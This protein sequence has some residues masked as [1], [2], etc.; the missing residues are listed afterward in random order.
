MAD[1][2]LFSQQNTDACFDLLL[3]NGSMLNNLVIVRRVPNKRLVCRGDWNGQH[4]YAKIF[5]GSQAQRYAAR[6]AAGVG[7]L[8][9]ANIET[10]ALLYSGG[11]ADN[12]KVASSGVL[13]FSTVVGGINAEE[14]WGQSAR[15]EKVALAKKLVTELARHHNAGLMQTDLYLKNFLVKGDKIFTLDGDAIKPLPRLFTNQAALGNLAVLLSKF[16]VL[17][18]QQWLDSL[19]MAYAEARGWQKS[20]DT[21]R[22]QAL[23]MRHRHR[24][25]Q[26]Y[27][28]KKVFRQCTDVAIS[29]SWRHFLAMSRDEFSARLEHLLRDMPDTLIDGPSQQ[30]LKNGNTC[31]VGLTEINARKIVVKRYNIK[32]FWH[33]LG[34]FWR[35]SRAAASWSNAHR[36]I[37]HGIATA[38]PI[39]LMEQRFGPLRGEAYFLTEYIESVNLAD[40][41]QDTLLSQAQKQSVCQAIAEL[42]YKLSLLQIVHGDMKAS[43]IHI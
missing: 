14:A 28:N 34:R 11:L 12:S 8:L 29:R 5:I 3:D 36:L 27:A 10:P 24:V 6:D 7:R 1:L 41:M 15:H 26:G 39:A 22:I 43:N 20:L 33:L 18:I 38:K 32:S 35:P 23:I 13:I 21:R 40:L 2:I 31:T 30:I 19:L 9:R 4:V 37:M 16:D 42:M 25:V 17:E